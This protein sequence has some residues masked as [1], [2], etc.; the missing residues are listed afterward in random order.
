MSPAPFTTVRAF[1]SSASGSFSAN[2][3]ILTF[4][5]LAPSAGGQHRP[6]RPIGSDPSEIRRSHATLLSVYHRT[7]RSM[8]SCNATRGA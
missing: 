3:G 2:P 8:P 6:E 7:V 4:T 1:W 5:G